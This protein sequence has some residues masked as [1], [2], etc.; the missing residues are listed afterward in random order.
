MFEKYLENENLSLC[1]QSVAN[2]KMNFKIKRNV[3][4]EDN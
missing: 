1:G 4:T 2:R 3:K